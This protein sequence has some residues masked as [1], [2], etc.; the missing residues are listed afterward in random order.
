M[1]QK[2]VFLNN[3]FFSGSCFNFENKKASIN[4]A[5]RKEEEGGG[6]KEIWNVFKNI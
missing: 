6:G 1:T 4:T 5:G 2:K 3:S